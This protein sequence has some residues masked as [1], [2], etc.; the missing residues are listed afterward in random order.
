MGRKKRA[1]AQST[2]QHD[3]KRAKEM[4]SETGEK[5][6]V[7]KYRPDKVYAAMEAFVKYTKSHRMLDASYIRWKT[8][9]TPEK[10]FVFSTRVGGQDLGWGRGKTRE[11]AMDAAC[12]AAFALVAAHGY[13]NFPL[14]DDC[15]MEPPIDP[16]PPPPPPPLPPPGVPGMYS[17][18]PPH[19]VLPG[20]PPLPPG[21]PPPPGFHV[22][23]LP[24]AQ[25][26]TVDLIPQAKLVPEA[27]PAASSLSSGP[28]AIQ[29]IHGNAALAASGTSNLVTPAVSTVSLTLSGSEA[30]NRT[31]SPSG[32]VTASSMAKKKLKGGLTLVFDPDG[33]NEREVSM[34]ESR[35]LLPRYQKMLLRALNSSSTLS[36][37][38]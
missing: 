17:A 6:L 37:T 14:D 15:M 11:A 26:S 31:T 8:G 4:T 10:P 20:M 24:A 13:N 12:R 16:L 38:A 2:E 9:V 33:E 1:G 19:M 27:P 7:K 30:A 28:I 3:P 34:E 35:A 32:Q 21:L 18:V 36:A 29:S 23:T 25:N 5:Y 22:P